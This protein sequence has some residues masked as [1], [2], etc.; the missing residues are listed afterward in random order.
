MITSDVW[1]TPNYFIPTRL[2]RPFQAT[3]N[4]EHFANIVI[5]PTMGQTISKYE[6]LAKDPETRD[7][8]TTAFGKEL[9]SLAQGD[10]RTDT[11]GTVTIFFMTHQ[12]IAKIPKNRVM[13]YARIVV[14][15]RPQKA[16]PNRV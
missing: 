16:D 3:P 6:T 13:T 2:K 9:G 1:N 5:H 4:L 11:P 10:N 7:I 12:Q 14:D 15:F 8:W